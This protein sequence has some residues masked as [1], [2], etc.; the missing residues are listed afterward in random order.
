MMGDSNGGFDP[1]DVERLRSHQL[2]VVGGIYARKGNREFTCK[3]LPETRKIPFGKGGG[4][5]EIMYAAAVIPVCIVL[6]RIL[7]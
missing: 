3:F 5:F 6:G 2:R 1:D 4:L 7:H